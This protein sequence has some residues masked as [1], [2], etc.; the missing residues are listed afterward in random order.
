MSEFPRALF[1]VARR[2]ATFIGAEH[3]GAGFHGA[4]PDA[5]FKVLAEDFHVGFIILKHDLD[6]VLISLRLDW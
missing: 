6:F 5:V 4:L 2:Y 1:A 3:E